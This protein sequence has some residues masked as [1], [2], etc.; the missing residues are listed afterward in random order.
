[1]CMAGMLNDEK[2][3]TPA[4]G[5]VQEACVLIQAGQRLADGLVQLLHGPRDAIDGLAYGP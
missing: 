2:G 1:M 5:V 3:K 4:I